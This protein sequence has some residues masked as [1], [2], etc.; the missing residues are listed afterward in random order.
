MVE[1]EVLSLKT[2]RGAADPGGGKEAWDS[3][4]KWNTKRAR[5]KLKILSWVKGKG[6]SKITVLTALESGMCAYRFVVGE[7]CVVHAIWR[8]KAL[9]TGQCVGN[10]KVDKEEK[11]F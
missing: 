10:N 1:A 2:E 11:H 3:V 8:D 5:A 9:H 7:R 4:K 6:G